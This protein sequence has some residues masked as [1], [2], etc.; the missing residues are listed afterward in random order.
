MA[1]KTYSTIQGDMWDSIAYKVY[2][3]E[4]CMTQLLQANETHKEITVFPAGV[5]LVCPDIPAESSRIL[6][7]W[8]R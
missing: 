6:P 1:R 8:R 2:G 5:K 3:R 7:P 4:K